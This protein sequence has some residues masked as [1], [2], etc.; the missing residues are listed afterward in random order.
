MRTHTYRRDGTGNGPIS[1]H[2]RHLHQRLDESQPYD[3]GD[4]TVEQTTRGIRFWLKNPPVAGQSALFNWQT[5]KKELDPTAAVQKFT[6]VYISPKN[7]LV[8][9]GLV[10]LV[11]G[12]S[13]VARPGIWQA[14]QAVPAQNS[15]TLKYNV[16]QIPLPGSGG[17]PSG[18]PLSGDADGPDVFW[19]LWSPT[20]YC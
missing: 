8:T 5:P 15:T 14:V 16:P 1:D 3:S 2:L 11:L 13:I 18:S 20:V 9:T 6:F 10:D 17:V 4:I 12:V 19:I 7:P